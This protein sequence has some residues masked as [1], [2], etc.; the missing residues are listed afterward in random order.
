M[1]HSATVLG[2][3]TSYS[4]HG[5]YSSIPKSHFI[6]GT[7]DANKMNRIIRTQF[8]HRC[9]PCSV[10]DLKYR[11]RIW[12]KELG[13]RAISMPQSSVAGTALGRTAT[14]SVT[15]RP[16]IQALQQTLS[17]S[18]GWPS[19]GAVYNVTHSAGRPHN[20]QRKMVHFC[21]SLPI[22]HS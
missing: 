13:W 9:F 5:R 8:M 14:A 18:T 22:L 6:S 2:Y 4:V 17:A 21:C 12:E 11:A 1:F 3:L 16:S 20:T 10:A 7:H 15:G 19:T